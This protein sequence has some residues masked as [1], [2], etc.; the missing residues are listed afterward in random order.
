MKVWHRKSSNS[1]TTFQYAR[2]KLKQEFSSQPFKNFLTINNLKLFCLSFT[3][4]SHPYF[5]YRKSNFLRK[6]FHLVNFISRQ[7]KNFPISKLFILWYL[8]NYSILNLTS[9]QFSF[10]SFYY[11]L[12]KHK[13]DKLAKIYSNNLS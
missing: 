9:S 11:F 1:S 13:P 12:C 7:A 10:F 2:Q 5:T 6:I 8:S 4:F 3:I